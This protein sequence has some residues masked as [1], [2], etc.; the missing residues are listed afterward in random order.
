M[1]KEY[2][3]LHSLIIEQFPINVRIARERGR[4]RPL[5]G[6]FVPFLI[7]LTARSK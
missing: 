7:G 5:Y 1:S 4:L 6:L 3:A 2:H